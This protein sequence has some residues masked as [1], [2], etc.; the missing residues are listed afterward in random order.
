MGEYT[1][2]LLQG[3]GVL[4]SAPTKVHITNIDTTY[5]I[6]QWSTPR[7]LGDTVRYYNVHYRMM[8]TYDNEYKTITNVNSPFVL[9]GLESNTDY[10]VYVDAANTHGVGEPSSRVIFQT[11]SQVILFTIHL[12]Y[13]FHLFLSKIYIL[14]YSCT[15][16]PALELDTEN[17]DCV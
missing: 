3:Y 1:N 15:L 9:E 13:H 12:I 8:A 17:L 2:C 16:G 7:T 11:E 4:P 6:V 5:A 14:L 10:E